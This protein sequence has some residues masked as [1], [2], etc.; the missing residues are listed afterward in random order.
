MGDE[1]RDTGGRGGT[2]A[3]ETAISPTS[4]GVMLSRYELAPSRQRGQ[5]FLS[6]ANVTRK[7]VCAAGLSPDDV[8]VEI[9]PGFGALTFGLAQVARH[10]VAVEIDSGIAGAFRDEYGER[11]DITL[12]VGD[13]LEFDFAKAAR[14]HGVK[15]L[16]IVG[17]I[18]YNITSP[19][20][21]RLTS[22]RDRVARSL[23]MVQ[24]EVGARIASEPGESDYSGLSVVTRY[25]ARVRRLFTVKKT[26]FHPRPKV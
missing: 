15:K 10:V 24:S 11:E 19:L 20:V 13:I 6:D 3:E 16:V 8:V 14:H 1:N 12:V 2:P 18:P 26:C 25:H 7:V 5:N 4:P 21:R 17:N 9:G 23:L 22:E